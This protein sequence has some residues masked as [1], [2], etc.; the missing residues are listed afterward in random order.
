MKTVNDV[1]LKKPTKD[2]GN[3]IAK[4]GHITEY[5]GFDIFEDKTP[6]KTIDTILSVGHGVSQGGPAIEVKYNYYAD[7]KSTYNS[8]RLKDNNLESLKRQIDKF[9]TSLSNYGSRTI[10][11]RIKKR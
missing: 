5:N 7:G 4:G 8:P 11:E 3:K 9:N 6:Q 1:K 2:A 10:A